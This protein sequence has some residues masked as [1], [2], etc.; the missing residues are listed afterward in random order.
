LLQ[1][2][3]ALFRRQGV[4]L[5]Q[6]PAEVLLRALREL[7]EKLIAGQRLLLLFWRE[8]RQAQEQL[9]HRAVGAGPTHA[10]PGPLH[11]GLGARRRR[12][13]RPHAGAGQAEAQ[14]RRQHQREMS[15]LLHSVLPFFSSA[16]GS[17]R[18]SN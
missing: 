10:A 4:E 17:N 8:R 9:H 1:P 2:P 15:C 5:R 16:A 14:H 6:A 12:F 18:I 13:L 11:R 3:L 7:L